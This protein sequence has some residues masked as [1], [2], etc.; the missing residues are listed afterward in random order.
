MLSQLR[1]TGP[2]SIPPD[3]TGQLVDVLARSGVDPSDLPEELQ[4][5]IVAHE[6]VPILQVRA[7]DRGAGPL[8]A[9]VTFDY[10]GMLVDPGAGSTTFDR[11]KRRLVRRDLAFEDEATKRLAS[12]GFTRRWDFGFARHALSISPAQ[13][14]TA[15]RALASEGWRVE[16]EGRA[17]R[18]AQPH[19]EFTTT[20]VV[21]GSAKV[22]STSSTVRS[23]WMPARVSSSRIGRRR[24]SG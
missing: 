22:L 21:P 6:P 18:A 5:E 7:D 20:S 8:L 14:P 4:F 11:Q 9:T 3:A 12:A 15:V 24:I 1:G 10:E 2:L 13:L 23:S 17:F 16:A 19:T